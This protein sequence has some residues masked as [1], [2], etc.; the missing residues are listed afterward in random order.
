MSQQYFLIVTA[1]T[2]Q[3]EPPSQKSI[4][5]IPEKLYI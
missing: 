5:K 1:D 2:Q 3:N 4:T